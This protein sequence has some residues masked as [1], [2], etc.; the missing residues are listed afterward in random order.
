MN[1]SPQKYLGSEEL[2]AL[3]PLNAELNSIRYLLVLLGAHPI[4]H[5]S[6]L[7]VNPTSQDNVYIKSSL[8]NNNQNK[9]IEEEMVNV[10]HDDQY[11][12]YNSI[13]KRTQVN[14]MK[15]DYY[16]LAE[17]KKLHGSTISGSEVTSE[18]L[19]SHESNIQPMTA[20]HAAQQETL[21]ETKM[22][23]DGLH[24]RTKTDE[25]NIASETEHTYKA[26][27]YVMPKPTHSS[28]EIINS[29]TDVTVG[30]DKLYAQAQSEEG[31]MFP[32]NYKTEAELQ[33]SL[34][35]KPRGLYRP[36][37]SPS[38]SASFPHRHSPVR[39]SHGPDDSD[40]QGSA[41]SYYSSFSDIPHK[42]PSTLYTSKPT[43]SFGLASASSTYRKPTV[44]YNSPPHTPPSTLYES[45]SQKKPSLLYGSP[46]RKPLSALYESTPYKQLGI[47][48]DFPSADLHGSSSTLNHSP[49][50]GSAPHKTS[51]PSHNIRPTDSYGSPTASFSSS[52]HGSRLT[53][54][55][56]KPL[57]RPSR[58]PY[59]SPPNKSS[60]PSYHLHSGH[61]YESPTSYSSLPHDSRPSTSTK[62]P[63]HKP[64]RQSYSSAQASHRP[65]QSS[66]LYESPS[67]LYG[68]IHDPRLV[69]S[70]SQ[71][72]GSQK[73]LYSAPSLGSP[74]PS[75]NLQSSEL[76]KSPTLLYSYSTHSSKP[77]DSSLS[78]GLHKPSYGSPPKKSQ[79]LPHNSEFTD[80][81]ESPS[82]SHS[83][84][85][86]SSIYRPSHGSLFGNSSWSHAS[87]HDSPSTDSTLTSYG[88][89]SNLVYESPSSTFHESLDYSEGGSGGSSHAFVKTD[90][91]HI[92]WGVRHSVSNQKTGSHQ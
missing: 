65:L 85:H 16:L 77:S 11:I 15:Y 12:N 80:L 36:F 19:G 64:H 79:S 84:S 31:D 67:S 82:S 50:Y 45:P 68:T 28:V 71:T 70:G 90:H 56:I 13:S 74:N 4:L 60:A 26:A 49:Q 23:K 88:S 58:H 73:P 44:I 7:R 2:M 5:I 54:S 17:H 83:L 40:F 48:H 6:R 69:I 47:S 14:N 57:H 43:D 38:R 32:G 86:G 72:L 63:S 27:S 87:I 89:P 34:H 1:T 3:N 55:E 61:L 75:Y 51:R 76:H 46:P 21:N 30:Q 41:S 18:D 29:E 39:T 66:E 91:G 62:S 53:I 92:K 22:L 35:G 59:S 52:P 42:S 8:G 81:Y 78:H 10:C 25:D 9:I 24:Y 20:S 33:I 37:F